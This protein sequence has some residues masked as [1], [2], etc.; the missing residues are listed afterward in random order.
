MEKK[1]LYTA[2]GL[3]EDDEQKA[4]KQ[5]E[6]AGKTIQ[7]LSSCCGWQDLSGSCPWYSGTIYRV[8]PE[9]KPTYIIEQG[10]MD[11]FDK[12]IAYWEKCVKQIK[13]DQSAD[14]FHGLCSCDLCC[15]HNRSYAGDKC[16]A[17]CILGRALSPCY[18]DGGL[19]AGRGAHQTHKTH[20]AFLDAMIEVRSRCSVKPEEEKPEGAQWTQETCPFPCMVRHVDRKDDWLSIGEIDSRGVRLGNWRFISFNELARE[21]E[22]RCGL[23]SYQ[24][25]GGAST[26]SMGWK[27][28]WKPCRTMELEC[29]TH[30]T[31][32]EG[33]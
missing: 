25:S 31:R 15:Y 21:W 29:E 27:W 8:K 14:V 2:F 16:C 32:E 9:E 24:C 7:V 26:C 10:E 1:Y 19:Y 4:L 5:A 18:K 28:Q 13:K 3:M 12:T 11:A 17:D 6:K 22:H 20:R 33:C 23:E 30:S